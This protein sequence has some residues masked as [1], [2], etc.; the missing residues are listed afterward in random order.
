MLQWDVSK[1]ISD[2]FKII[3]ELSNQN[4]LIVLSVVFKFINQDKLLLYLK[5]NT[6]EF[7]LKYSE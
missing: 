2:P 3:G 1:Y 4:D 7:S 6:V 5:K